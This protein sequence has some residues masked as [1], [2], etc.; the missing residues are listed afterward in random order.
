MT[1]PEEQLDWQLCRN[2]VQLPQLVQDCDSVV[3]I[4]ALL[5]DH[6][7]GQV[8]NLTWP[9]HPDST[10]SFFSTHGIN[11]IQAL[12]LAATLDQLPSRTYL[13]GLSVTN[14]EQDTTAVVTKALP[15]LQQALKRIIN[16]IAE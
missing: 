3:I 16:Q 15:Q 13:L 1:L 9:I 8:I 12:Q 11:V 14:Q 2:P 10:P 7:A 6:P 4:D 5:S